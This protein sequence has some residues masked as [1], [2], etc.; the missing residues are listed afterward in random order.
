[1]VFNFSCETYVVHPQIIIIKE[2]NN[3]EAS[4]T[5][6]TNEASSIAKLIDNKSKLNVVCLF[7]KR[8]HF[9][10]QVIVAKR[11]KKNGNQPPTRAI[12]NHKLCAYLTRG[13]PKGFV[14][15]FSIASDQIPNQPPNS[16]TFA[17]ESIS[18]F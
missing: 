17:Y 1:M 15:N 18:R 8:K 3:I 16:E 7:A 5:G 12:S 11:K 9:F 2:K 14:A 6:S 4:I 13:Q 10:T